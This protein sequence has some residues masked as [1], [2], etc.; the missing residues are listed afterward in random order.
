[1]LNSP[2][3]K[4]SR[5]RTPPARAA[6]CFGDQRSGA[7]V[8]RIYVK[9]TP[10]ASG[11]LARMCSRDTSIKMLRTLLFGATSE[12]RV[13]KAGQWETN[14]ANVRRFYEEYGR[15]PLPGGHG[16]EGKLGVWAVRQRE[17]NRRNK[18]SWRCARRLDRFPGWHW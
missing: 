10:G 15:L 5:Q 7:P 16:V 3:C 12:V 1:V 8:E 11:L 17:A 2:A 6:F 9:Q 18:L 13:A 14:F 4:G